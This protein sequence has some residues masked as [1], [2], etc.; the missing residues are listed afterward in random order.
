[1]T[2]TLSFTNQGPSIAENVIITDEL[3]SKV[4]FNS[5]VSQP[6][7]F[8]GPVQTG[9]MLTWTAPAMSVGENGA[10]V[11]TVLVDPDAIDPLENIASISSTTA[12]LA[13]DNNQDIEH[14][15]ISSPNLA[16]IYG[17][18]YGDT[19]GNGVIDPAETGIPDVVVTMDG[20]ITATTGVDGFYN[21]ITAVEGIH[22]LV[23]SDPAGYTSTTPNEVQVLVSLGNSY[24]VDYGDLA[25]CTCPPDDFENDDSA[26]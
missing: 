7:S 9:Q 23:E 15:L 11:Y 14:T 12:D 8:S 17:W 4:T 19:N 21:F 22:I 2:Y 24:R 25:L 26:G 1:M 13:L 6:P 5:V 16:N 3:P 20:V 10:I 18:V